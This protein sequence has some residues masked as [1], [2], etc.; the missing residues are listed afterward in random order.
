MV[1]N[2]VDNTD[3]VVRYVYTSCR[4]TFMGPLNLVRLAAGF[5]CPRVIYGQREGAMHKNIPEHR[6][7][8]GVALL[9]LSLLIALSICIVLFLEAMAS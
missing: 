5:V 1:E 2:R 6:L 4:E 8:W 9:A 7:Y 3:P